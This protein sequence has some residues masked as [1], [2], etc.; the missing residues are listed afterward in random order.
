[1]M[2][3][4]TVVLNALLVGLIPGLWEHVAGP[5]GQ[6]LDAPQSL[7]WFRKTLLL[8]MLLLFP[9]CG[10]LVDRLGVRC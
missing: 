1:M 7:R 5:L 2:L 8:G 9:L 3:V 4:P 10:F 6:R